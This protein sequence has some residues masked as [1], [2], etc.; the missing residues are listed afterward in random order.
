MSIRPRLSLTTGAWLAVLLCAPLDAQT[1]RDSAASRARSAVAAGDT[2]HGTV[3]VVGRPLTVE[4]VIDGDAVALGGDIVVR[5]GGTVL[6]DATAFGGRVRL[7]GGLVAGATRAFGASPVEERRVAATPKPWESAKVAAGWFAILAVIGIGVLMFAEGSLT[8]VAET[9]E[10]H[11]AR[12]FGYGL[13]AQFALLPGLLLIVTALALTVVGILLIPFAVVAYLIAFAGLLTLGFLA[14]SR[15]TGGAFGG[16]S[17]EGSARA[18]HLGALLRGL[19]V[20]FAVWLVAALFAWHPL[21]GAVLRAVAVAVS[22]V[23]ATLGLGAAIASRVEARR[24]AATRKPLPMDPM[25]WQT[26]TPVTGVAAARRAKP[27]ARTGV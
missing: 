25:V 2:V 24:N 6:G 13:L 5:Q 17:G 26:P 7:E 19:A 18:M 16:R 22:W 11:F 14:V 1:P 3:T 9:L 27:V 15:F 20:Y 12:S 10:R 4:G 21:V 8:S 23:V